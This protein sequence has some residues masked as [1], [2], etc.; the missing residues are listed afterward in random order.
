MARDLHASRRSILAERSVLALQTAKLMTQWYGTTITSTDYVLRDITTKVTPAELDASSSDPGTQKRL[1]VLVREKVGTRPGVYGLGFVNRRCIFIAAADE[2]VIGIPS[3][4]RLRPERT[5]VLENCAFIEY[6]P[7]SRSA[8]KQPAILVSRPILSPSGRFMGG[9]GPA[10]NGLAVASA[11]LQGLRGPPARVRGRCLGW[12]LPAQ[13]PAGV[14]C[15]G[16]HLP[17]P[18][19]APGTPSTLRGWEREDAAAVV[20]HLAAQGVPRNRIV[21]VGASQGA[22]LTFFMNSLL[23]VCLGPRSGEPLGRSWQDPSNGSASCLPR[24]LICIFRGAA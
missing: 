13:G 9:R 3:N 2:R 8:N 6:V 22:G 4:S 10:D 17:Q 23:R 24:G 5:P 19:L 11:R 15:D 7:A 21:L 20:R 18:G 16:L 1:S 12:R 14:G